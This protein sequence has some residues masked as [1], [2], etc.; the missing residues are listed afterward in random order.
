MGYQQWWADDQRFTSYL[1]LTLLQ[2]SLKVWNLLFFHYHR[3]YRF[4]IILHLFLLQVVDLNVK[5]EEPGKANVHNNAFYAEEKLLRSELQAMRDCKPRHWIVR[6]SPGLWSIFL[7]LLNSSY[8]PWTSFMHDC[9]RDF[10]IA[11]FVVR[12]WARGPFP[13]PA[14]WWSVGESTCCQLDIFCMMFRTCSS[15]LPI[16]FYDPFSK[17][18]IRPPSV[19]GFV[20]STTWALFYLALYK[21]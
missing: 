18:Y 20:Y 6:A 17:L 5:V 4:K 12:V 14:F 21:I 19:Y 8:L 11:W 3:S 15:S 16:L 7:S 1:C 9:R 10:S 2:W 13:F